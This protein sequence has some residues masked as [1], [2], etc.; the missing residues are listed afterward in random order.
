MRVSGGTTHD[1][2]FHGSICY[3]STWENSF[4][5][6][7]DSREY[8]MLESGE[9]WHE[10]KTKYSSFPYYGLWRDVST[11]QAPGDFH[12]TYRDD[13]DQGRDLRLWMTDDG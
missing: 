13:S 10:P 1:Y 12:I 11:N 9:I 5:L 4:D 6:A 8:P 3:D 2:V 7:L